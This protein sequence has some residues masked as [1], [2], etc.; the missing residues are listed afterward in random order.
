MSRGLTGIVL[1]GYGARDYTLTLLS[2]R[3]IAPHFVRFRFASAQLFQEITWHPATWLRFWFPDPAG[4]R[5]ELQRAYTLVAAYPEQGEFEIDVLLHEP[6]GPA[7]LWFSQAQPGDTIASTFLGS[8]FRMPQPEPAGF[9]LIGDAC[10][11][12]AINNL[13]VAAQPQTALE[14]YLESSS[15]HDAAIPIEAHPQLRL[16]RIARSSAGSLVAALESRDRSGWYA[17]GAGEAGTMKLLHKALKDTHG[18]AKEAIH[19]Q[20]YWAENHKS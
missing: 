1:K 13:I 18:F 12:P 8:R 19:V 11:T 16:H 20:S 14:V 2:K 15:P 7:T 5:R 6:P 10:S 3:E 9:L 4:K 17:W